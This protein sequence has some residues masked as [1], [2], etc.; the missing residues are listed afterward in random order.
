MSSLLPLTTSSLANTS[1]SLETTFFQ[2][3]ID[4]NVLMN[5]TLPPLIS[6]GKYSP[7]CNLINATQIQDGEIAAI[8]DAIDQDQF[9][10]LNGGAYQM[11]QAAFSSGNFGLGLALFNR[12]NVHALNDCYFID[13]AIFHGCPDPLLLEMIPK[14]PESSFKPFFGLP[15]AITHKRSDAVLLALIEKTPPEVLQAYDIL[16]LAKAYCSQEVIQKIEIKLASLPAAYTPSTPYVSFTQQFEIASKEL[17]EKDKLTDCTYLHL[18]IAANCSDETLIGIIQKTEPEAFQGFFGLEKAMI[19]KRSKEVLL[20]LINKI[21]P[22]VLGANQSF[23]LVIS[24]YSEDVASEILLAI[25]ERADVRALQHNPVLVCTR[26]E[27]LCGKNP[28]LKQVVAKIKSI[29]SQ[30]QLSN[31]SSSSSTQEVNDL[32]RT[33]APSDND[34]NVLINPSSA[35]AN[36]SERF[37]DSSKASYRPQYVSFYLSSQPPIQNGPSY[38]HYLPRA[39][40]PSS[41]SSSSSAPTSFAN[42]SNLSDDLWRAFFTQDYVK[43]ESLINQMSP[44]DFVNCGSVRQALCSECSDDLLLALIAKVPENVLK[45]P[46]SLFPLAVGKKA[47]KEVLR[48][49]MEKIGQKNI[50]A[51]SEDLR[52]T[53]FHLVFR[54]YN[55]KDAEE[56]AQEMFEKAQTL[57]NQCAPLGAKDNEGCYPLCRAIHAKCFTIAETWIPYT[58][59]DRFSY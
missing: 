40:P 32:E 6:A 45:T 36:P 16:D 21:P 56:L 48:A 17:A 18:A 9:D 50:E 59:K 52:T 41:S 10:L 22:K 19:Q 44:E 28:V 15:S 57:E 20:A 47:S 51:W 2:T 12:M 14:I 30:N 43:A 42:S 29:A 5:Q 35:H 33:I 11:L 55:T 25:L 31:A 8:M 46:H 13:L 1:S 26:M 39:I 53:A 23:D 4:P 58:P 34:P 24:H 49:L 3:D 27:E 37:N 7:A 38:P 54:K